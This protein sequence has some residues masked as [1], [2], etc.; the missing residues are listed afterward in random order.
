MKILNK[1]V[2]FAIVFLV[3]FYIAGNNNITQAGACTNPP[4]PCSDTFAACSD[5]SPG[6][7]GDPIFCCIRTMALN[8]GCCQP[9]AN[10]YKSTNCGGGGDKKYIFNGGVKATD[11]GN[12]LYTPGADGIN[13]SCSGGGCA[14]TIGW[15]GG[16]FEGK[17]KERVNITLTLS[18]LPSGYNTCNVSVYDHELGER[19]P[20]QT[21]PCTYT[22][23]MPFDNDN[24]RYTFDFEMIAPGLPTCTLNG[25]TNVTHNV[26]ALYTLT[27]SDPN[28]NLNRVE[29]F[30][31]PAGASRFG[32]LVFVS[33]TLLVQ[34]IS[35]SLVQPKEI[36]GL[37]VMLIRQAQAFGVPETLGVWAVQMVVVGL[38]AEGWLPVIQY[39]RPTLLVILIVIPILV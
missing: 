15:S 35:P 18:N 36:I 4:E 27:G 16:G 6:L 33:G 37:L 39:R 13:I 34:R 29:M 2:L 19:S 30:R 21:G 31:S 11:T 10:T 38:V 22:H 32:L 23:Y 3:L 20:I 14:G 9:T 1:I 7:C 24:W 26:S 8:A 28:N 25:P 17:A 12:R 5:C